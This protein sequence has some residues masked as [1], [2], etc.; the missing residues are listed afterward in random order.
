MASQIFDVFD[1]VRLT[2]SFADIV[3][4]PI[5]PSTV[6][7]YMRDPAL[8]LTTHVYSA[9]EVVRVDVGVYYVDFEVNTVGKHW[10]RFAGTGSGQTAEEDFFN[11]R[12][13][14]VL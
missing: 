6:T 3:N 5:D 1:V 14:N 8:N 2:G 10:W 12:S 13:S 4:S 9:S 11:V 7:F